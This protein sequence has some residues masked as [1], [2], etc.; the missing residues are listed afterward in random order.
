M[1]MNTQKVAEEK[2]GFKKGTK[3]HK[4]VS[5]YLRKSGATTEQIREACGGAYLNV[6]KQVEANG[7]TVK[8]ERQNVKGKNK[9]VYRITL[10]ASPKRTSK[11]KK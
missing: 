5:M 3:T 11:T 6:L 10:V 1:T 4:A 9:T 8:R 2:L 7:H